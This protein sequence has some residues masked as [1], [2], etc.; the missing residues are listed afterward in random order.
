MKET[1]FMTIIQVCLWLI[2]FIFLTQVNSAISYR[3]TPTLEWLFTPTN[4]AGSA[5]G[6]YLREIR[7][8]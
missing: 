1:R 4:E 3:N 6:T 7:Q 2:A 5:L 8:N